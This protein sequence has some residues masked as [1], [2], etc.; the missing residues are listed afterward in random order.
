MRLSKMKSKKDAVNLALQEF[1]QR[2]EQLKILNV[3]GT[4]EL[5]ESFDYKK[6]R[7]AR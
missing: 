4:I 5:D 3:F 1:E 6:Q 7:K 2:R